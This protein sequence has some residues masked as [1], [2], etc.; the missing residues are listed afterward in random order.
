MTI[1]AILQSQAELAL[2][3]SPIPALRRLRIE[4]SESAV[5]IAGEVTSYYL[6]QLAQETIM[7][8]LGS[9]ELQNRVGVVRN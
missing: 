7:P 8:F 5:V 6:K 1:S 3:Q 9:R 4:E 2:Q